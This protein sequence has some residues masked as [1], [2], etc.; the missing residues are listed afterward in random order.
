[1]GTWVGAFNYALTILRALFHV[2]GT[3]GEAKHYKLHTGRKQPLRSSKQR[4]NGGGG[5]VS[6]M[7]AV[8]SPV[9]SNCSTDLYQFPSDV[10]RIESYEPSIQFTIVNCTQGSNRHLFTNFADSSLL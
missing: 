5:G 3:K 1:M 7:P 4:M 8:K 9:I 2:Q 6:K 10:N